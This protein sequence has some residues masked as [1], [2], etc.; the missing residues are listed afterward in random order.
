MSRGAPTPA[1]LRTTGL[2]VA[3]VALTAAVGTA[4]ASCG[5]QPAASY[6]PK[7][8][9]GSIEHIEG[10]PDDAA[11]TVTAKNFT[12]QLVLGKIA[13]IALTAAGF[14]VTDMTNVPGSQA[15]RQLMLDGKADMTFEYTGTAWLTY[16]G[17]KEGIPD[18]EKQFEAVRDADAA[19]GLTWLPPA[20]MNNTYA[21]AV[22][23]GAVDELG[24]ITKLS[25][26]KDLPV[27]QRTFC[28][29]S[30]FNSRPDGF[31]PMLEKYGLKLG[32]SG[33]DGV[34]TRNVKILDTG[35]VYT[36]TADGTCNFGEVFTTDGRITSL[37]LQVLADDKGF[38]PA[39]N[40]APVV[41]TATLDEYPG[42][43]DV[44]SGLT[45]KL[46]NDVMRS[47][48]R[49]VDVDGEDPGDVAFDWM[50]SEGFVTAP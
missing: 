2:R 49:K 6:V 43:K 22:R 21:L 31:R 25:Q 17:H 42:I 35:T 19:N 44:F 20:P 50:V 32:S 1:G 4:L 47:L 15:V 39:Y 24:G 48:N 11:I 29:E 10:L 41:N 46:T 30:E 38:F 28:V 14:H 40:G 7:A 33:K 13:V 26:L 16:L 9:P 5:L 36:A 12:E 37:N 23:A 3:V 18:P 27:S 45:P 34:P 8:D